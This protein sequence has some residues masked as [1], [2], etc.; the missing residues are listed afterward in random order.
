MK[1]EPITVTCPAHAQLLT[2]LPND[3]WGD[4][5]GSVPGAT[6]QL[7]EL[8]PGKCCMVA[9]TEL[10]AAQGKAW[11]SYLDSNKSLADLAWLLVWKAEYRVER[12]YTPAQMLGCTVWADF[13]TAAAPPTCLDD[14][15]QLVRLDYRDSDPEGTPVCYIWAT[16]TEDPNDYSGARTD[17]RLEACMALAHLTKVSLW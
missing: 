5:L 2:S 1:T 15:L 6:A 7:A 13:Y 16:V 10:P 12:L 8:L 4:Q 17:K 9:A 3:F 11:H 14:E